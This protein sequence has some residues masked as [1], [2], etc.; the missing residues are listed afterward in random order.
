MKKIKFKEWFKFDKDAKPGMIFLFVCVGLAYLLDFFFIDDALYPEF[1]R[2]WDIFYKG[3]LIGLI[4]Y[5]IIFIIAL[6]ISW[7]ERSKYY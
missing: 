6:I 3:L 4:F 7:K 5:I 1:I 2:E